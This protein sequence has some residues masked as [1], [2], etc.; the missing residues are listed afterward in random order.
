VKLVSV[1]G[2]ASERVELVAAL[3]HRWQQLGTA[4]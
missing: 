4:Y 2:S 3:L 1:C